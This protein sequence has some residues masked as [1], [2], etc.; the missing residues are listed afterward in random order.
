MGTLQPQS[1]G[2]LHSNTVTGTLAVDGGLLHLVQRG[3]QCCVKYSKIGIKIKYQMH[4]NFW[5][6]K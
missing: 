5:V 2:P 6:F 1:N 4:V 3:G